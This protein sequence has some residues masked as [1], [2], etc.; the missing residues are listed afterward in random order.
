MSQHYHATAEVQSEHVGENTRVWQHVIILAG[1]VIGRD[2]NLCSSVF[3][4]NDVVIGDRVT[5]KPGVQV[6]DGTRLEDDVFIGPNATLTN[7]MFPPS[8]NWPEKMQGIRVEKG[9]AIGANATILPGVTIGAGALV[10]AG[11]VVTRD[12]PAKAIV[13]GNPAR[14]VGHA[15]D[16]ERPG[17]GD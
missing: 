6:W 4:E 1:A 15:D 14:V 12:V 10:G 16:A 7:D 17:A 5:V 11:A 3:V 13:V 9:A 8:K 2:C